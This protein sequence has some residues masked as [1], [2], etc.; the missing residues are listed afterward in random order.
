MHREQAARLAPVMQAFADGAAVQWSTWRKGKWVDT[1][2]PNFD[3][4]LD[5]RVKPEAR[6]TYLFFYNNSEDTIKSVSLSDKELLEGF[7]KIIKEAGD[8]TKK[9]Q[10]VTEVV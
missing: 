3:Q 6:K 1:S 10:E 8:D 4:D 2:H 9:I 7:R 5:W